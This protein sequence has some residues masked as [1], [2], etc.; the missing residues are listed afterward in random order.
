MCLGLAQYIITDGSRFIY[1]N[2]AGNY[3]PAPSEMMADIFTKKQAEG[4]YGNSLPKALKAVFYIEKY[5]SPPD[6]VKQVN[7]IDLKNNTEKVMAAENIQKWLDKLSDLNGLAE[8]AGK[9][10]EELLKQLHELEDE[11][12]DI[13][14]YIEFQNLNAAQGYKASK[15]LKNCRI[16]RRSVKNELF[17]L[18]IILEQ[19]LEKIFDE[20]IYKKIRGLDNRTYKPRIRTDLF[21]L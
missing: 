21:D 17:V 19:K 16:K 11:K 1:R 10:K 6:D 14:H 5:D 7:Y 8:E 15:E 12:I 13:E 2:Q 4:I 3:V 18:E 9:R 20:E